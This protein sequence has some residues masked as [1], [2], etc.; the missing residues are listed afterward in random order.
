MTDVDNELATLTHNNT[1][2]SNSANNF[3]NKIQAFVKELTKTF[4]ITI[5][6]LNKLSSEIDKMNFISNDDTNALYDIINSYEAK[7]TEISVQLDRYKNSIINIKNPEID[8]N[9]VKL[10]ESDIKNFQSQY[11][12]V[13]S[14]IRDKLSKK[15]LDTPRVGISSSSTITGGKKRTRKH[16]THRKR[17]SHKKTKKHSR[18][19]NK[20]R[21]HRGGMI[22]DNTEE[23]DNEEEIDLTPREAEIEYPVEIAEK[24]ISEKNIDEN[25]FSEEPEEGKHSFFLNQ[26]DEQKGGYIYNSNIKR[27]SSRKSLKSITKKLT[28]KNRYSNR[29]KKF[30]SFFI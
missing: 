23:E 6:D 16:K 15:S 18:H 19:K 8:W 21:Y 28:N 24:D 5:K 7:L 3:Y 9:S 29:S 4:T 17:R 1:E 22:R 20:K 10:S 14:E 27:K 30:K 26:E 11:E 25:Y 2:Y 12:K 13:I